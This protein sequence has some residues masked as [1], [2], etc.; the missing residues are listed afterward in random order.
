MPKRSTAVIDVP[1]RLDLKDQLNDIANQLSS[2]ATIGGKNMSAAMSGRMKEVQKQVAEIQETLNKLSFN[3]LNAKTFEDTSKALLSQISDLEKRTSALEV[4]MQG[5]VDTLS[6]EDGSKMANAMKD[7]SS[8]MENVRTNTEQTVGV[9]KEFQN[10]TSKNGAT[11]NLVNSEELERLQKEKDLL[12]D[13]QKLIM[14]KKKPKSLDLDYSDANKTAE[15]IREIIDVV[16]RLDTALEEVNDNPK[17]FGSDKIAELQRSIL[18]NYRKLREIDQTKIGSGLAEGIDDA[19]SLAKEH[20]TAFKNTVEDRVKSVNDA[21]DQINK[22]VSSIGIGGSGTKGNQTMQSLKVPLDVKGSPTDLAKKAG[23]IVEAAQKYMDKY[24]LEVGFKLVSE[25]S[26]KKTNSLL[27]DLQKEINDLE[28]EATKLDFQDLYDRLA[29]DF[30]K[31]I[32]IEV[33]ADVGKESQKVKQVIKELQSSLDEK[34]RIFP[35]I[36]PDESEIGKIQSILDDISKNL[37]LTIGNITLSDTAKKKLEA[38]VDTQKTTSKKKGKKE[39][40]L[41]DADAEKIK[42]ITDSISKTIN[43]LKGQIGQINKDSLEP[44][45]DSLNQIGQLLIVIMQSSSALPNNFSEITSNIKEMVSV[46]Q[47]GFGLL[48]TDELD[49]K[50]ADIQN[51]ISKINGDLRGGDNNKRVLELKEL[52][53][54]YKEYQNLGGKNTIADLGGAKNVQKWLQNHVNDDISSD[55]AFGL[56]KVEESIDTISKKIDSKNEKFK[57]EASIV[58]SVASEETK[59]LKDVVDVL[60]QMFE[61]L[62]QINQ[63]GF[64]DWKVEDWRK[65]ISDTLTEIDKFNLKDLEGKELRSIKVQVEPIINPMEFANRVTSALSGVSAEINIVPSFNPNEI[66]NEIGKMLN[67]DRL[68]NE[69]AGFGG[70]SSNIGKFAGKTQEELQQCLA[71]EEKWLARCKE[72]SDAYDK[73]KANIEKINSLLQ[74]TSSDLGT[75]Q[76]VKATE[77]E[78]EAFNK[79]VKEAQEASESKEKFATAN[80]EVLSSIVESVKGLA[81]ETKGFEALNKLIKNLSKEDGMENTIKN[82]QAIA[83]LLK[84][85]VSDSSILSVLKDIAAQGTDLGD[86]ATLIKASK[87]EIEKAK[88]VVDKAEGKDKGGPTVVHNGL[89]PFVDKSSE[90]WKFVNAQVEKHKD[91]LGEVLNI[92]RKVDGELESFVVKGTNGNN[93]ILGK[94]SEDQWIASVQRI[95]DLNDQ[96]RES[97]KLVKSLSG[98]GGFIDKQNT[99]I[100]YKTEA[101]RIK[102]TQEYE[103]ELD[104]A[105]EKLEELNSILLKNESVNIWD[106]KDIQKAE[107]LQQEIKKIT[108]GLTKA[109]NMN[110]DSGTIDKLLSKISKDINDNTR[111]APELRERF[112]LLRDSIRQVVQSSEDLDKVSFKSFTNEFQHLHEEMLRTQQTGKGF[113][114]S[115]ADAARSQTT[116]FIARYFSLQDWIRYAQQGFEMVRNIDSALTELRKVSDASTARLTQNFETSSKAAQDLGSSISGVINI[117]ADWSRLNNLG[118]LYSNV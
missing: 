8:A 5:L 97:Q 23:A 116:Q 118:L 48:T 79:M 24:P 88:K 31:T 76:S 70:P 90:E 18:I 115:I 94:D 114:K 29:K 9:I 95:K 81:D 104:K 32:N 3:K 113:F 63:K 87:K 28:D 109:V 11:V 1:L 58:K 45:I 42:V 36:E 56:N 65:A 26:S 25:Y 83:D 73:R 82:L 6:K 2:L 51:R 15:K 44:I 80:G 100:E 93:L 53:K 7:L 85:E 60:Q 92:Y 71:T 98:T 68:Q 39:V 91:A 57:E 103:A 72:G 21:L 14:G 4:G 22:G 47:R 10:I 101:E 106:D 49:S 108:D 52:I 67:Q 102:Y 62:A 105:K 61:N 89:E 77:S 74:K 35:K 107:E 64:D 17:A 66:G 30:Q 13:I 41:E 59:T 16:N 99:K 84:T 86:I 50:F 69:I 33:S 27:S 40:V 34:L 96:Y 43:G 110:V 37:T 19:L 38:A 75:S 20:I 112:L 117:T 54:L 46:M 55:E 111:M 12:S 78:S